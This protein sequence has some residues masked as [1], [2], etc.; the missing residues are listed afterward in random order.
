MRIDQFLA[1]FAPG[2][3]ISDEALEIQEV[4]RSMGFISEIFVWPEFLHHGSR[5]KAHSITEYKKSEDS[6]AVIYHF[7]TGS[8]IS[9]F[10]TEVPGPKI[11]IYHNVTPSRYLVGYSQAIAAEL[12]EGREQLRA[13]HNCFDLALADS[14]FN[15]AELE[16]AGYPKTA[17]LPIL[18]NQD[19]YLT[20]PDRR[21]SHLYRDGRTNILYVSRFV[22]NKCQHDLIKV[23]YLYQKFCNSNS[24][25]I[26]VGPES[27]SSYF[28]EVRQMVDE[29]SLKDVLMPGHVSFSELLAFYR[30]SDVFVS[31]SEHEGFSVPVV[32]SFLLGV[33][34]IAFSAGAVPQTVGQAG[35]LLEKKDPEVVAEAVDAV[36]TSNWLHAELVRRGRERYENYFRPEI[37]AERLRAILRELAS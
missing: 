14:E 13:L 2:D 28:S 33:P 24:R 26:L 32:E 25:L 37:V 22:P 31:M 1:G 7:S 36:C 17:I 34:V 3:A 18:M 15:R 10:V 6:A 8:Q 29:L 35:I 27:V 4:I 23:F 19:K 11:M 21:T 9:Q 20:S 12:A 30:A 5:D 16:A